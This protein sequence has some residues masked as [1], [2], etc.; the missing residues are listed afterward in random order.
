[1]EAAPES[2]TVVIDIGS[3]ATKA[4]FAHQRTPQTTF[5]SVVAEENNVSK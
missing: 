4:G 5:R 2:R 1:M 3:F